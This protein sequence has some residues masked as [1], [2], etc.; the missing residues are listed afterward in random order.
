VS[1]DSF[2]VVCYFWWCGIMTEHVEEDDEH[3][4]DDE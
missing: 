4:K 3:N 1:Y 2:K